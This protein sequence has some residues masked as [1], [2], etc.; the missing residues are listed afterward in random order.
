MIVFCKS[1]SSS[2]A[3][4]RFPTASSMA[5]AIPRKA[6]LAELSSEES[7]KREGTWRGPCTLWKERYRKKGW[8]GW[9]SA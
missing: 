8:S 7:S 5:E 9:W 3:F 4:V 1:P 2:S 6:L